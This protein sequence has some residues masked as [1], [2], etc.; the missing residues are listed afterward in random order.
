VL[1]LEFFVIG[2]VEGVYNNPAKESQLDARLISSY[3]SSTFIR[4]GRI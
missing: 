4:F 2:A 1:L 3:I